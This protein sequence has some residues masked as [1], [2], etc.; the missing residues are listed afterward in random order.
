MLTIE[1]WKRVDRSSIN[2]QLELVTFFVQVQTQ[3]E[4]EF[5]KR[6]TNRILAT[7]SK[8]FP[9]ADFFSFSADSNP[10]KT[11]DPYFLTLFKSPSTPLEEE[12]SVAVTQLESPP[13]FLFVK[14]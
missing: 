8:L 5:G 14:E 3:F 13:N 10:P 9:F 11:S 2:L 4:T 1:I 12:T 7:I 6:E